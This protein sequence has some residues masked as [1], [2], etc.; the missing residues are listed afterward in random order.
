MTPSRFPPFICPTQQQPTVATPASGPVRS[1]SQVTG[2]GSSTRS[3]AE[4]VYD[5]RSVDGWV[6]DVEL[7]GRR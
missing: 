6:D 7:A 1:S 3:W 5:S 4:E 2:N